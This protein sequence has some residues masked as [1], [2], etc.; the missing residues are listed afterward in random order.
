V[1]KV[2]MNG[3]VVWEYLLPEEVKQYTQ[4]GFDAEQLTNG[5][6]L[7]V[8]VDIAVAGSESLIFEVTSESEIVWEMRLVNHH[9]ETQPVFFYKAQRL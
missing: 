6:T 8:A 2:D 3:N 5:N 9:V 1:V 7:L 4:P